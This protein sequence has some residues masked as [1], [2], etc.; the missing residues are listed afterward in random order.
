MPLSWRFIHTAFTGL[1]GKEAPR[2]VEKGAESSQAPSKPSKR[3]SEPQFWLPG[4]ADGIQY[5]TYFPFLT[6]TVTL[7]RAMGSSSVSPLVS[8][9][10]SETLRK[11]K[12][13]EMHPLGQATTCCCPH[14]Q[15]LV[16]DDLGVPGPLFLP[17]SGPF[18]VV[19]HILAV[20][21]PHNP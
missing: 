19:C 18:L 11:E 9:K 5:D 13:L 2:P 3:P 15:L 6:S 1:T 10:V 4:S 17:Q 21:L 7:T 8:Q 16:R 20:L 12:A 14:L